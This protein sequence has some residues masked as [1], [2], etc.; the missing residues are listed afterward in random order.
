M[1]FN[2]LTKN[3]VVF[4]RITVIREGSGDFEVSIS[5]E[6]GTVEGE[7]IPRTHAFAVTANPTKNF[8]QQAWDRL[9]TEADSYEAL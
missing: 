5:Y 1:P 8:L 6:V 4:N 2:P 3:S 9:Q 7:T